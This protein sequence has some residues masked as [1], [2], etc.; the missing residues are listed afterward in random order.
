MT[1]DQYKPRVWH[2][3]FKKALVLEHPHPDLDGYLQSLGIEVERIDDPPT[4]EDALIEILQRGGHNLIFKRSRVQITERVINATPNLFGVMLCCIGDDSVD[5]EACA[6][7]GVMVIN[8][9]ISNGR[10]VAEMVLGE[11]I[12]LS[13]RIIEAAQGEHAMRRIALGRE[14]FA[15]MTAAAFFA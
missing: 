12:C 15:R 14:V 1:Q 11:I 8:D 10:S 2:N 9:P 4:E 13:R 3:C 5:K 6:R 7:A